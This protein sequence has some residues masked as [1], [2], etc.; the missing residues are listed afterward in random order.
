MD[1]IIKRRQGREVIRDLGGLRM[2]EEA[3]LPLASLNPARYVIHRVNRTTT[4][5]YSAGSRIYELHSPGGSTW[6]M[7]SWS[8]QVHPGVGLS[9]LPR[10]GRRL[11]LPRGWRYGSRRLKR[12]LR[13]VTVRA[14]AQV[15]QDDLQDSYSRVT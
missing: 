10:L 1:A 4:F 14:A 2:I 7:Q 5:I 11:H 6:V 15:L 9:E 8:R 12:A 13:I 3:T